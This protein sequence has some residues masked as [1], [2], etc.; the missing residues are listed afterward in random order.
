MI[1]RELLATADIPA[2]TDIMGET[3]GALQLYQRGDDFMI[4]IGSN[5]LMNSRVYGSE[6]ALAKLSCA[7][8]KSIAAPHI[9]IGGYGMGFT[10]RSALSVLGKDASITIVELIPDIIAW[11]KGP[12]KSLTQD[13]LDDNRIT[14]QIADVKELITQGNR[15]YDAILLDVD[16]GPD[17]LTKAGNDSLYSD[18]GLMRAKSALNSG[19]VLAIWSAH[20]SPKFTKRLE[21]CGFDISTH[22]VRARNN[23]KGARHII[24]IAKKH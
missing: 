19:G 4:T 22:I 12:M 11:A 7:A 5:E 2:A 3:K 15:R 1:R 14:L 8:L 9:L 21:Q 6:Q 18:S 16:N 23:G 13:T 20:P 10:L 24:W 17:G